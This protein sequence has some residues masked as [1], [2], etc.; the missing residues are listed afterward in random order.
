MSVYL[1]EPNYLFDRFF[2]TAL[3][4]PQLQQQVQKTDGANAAL[5]VVRPR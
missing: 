1:Y 4:L 3:G 5:S 2:E